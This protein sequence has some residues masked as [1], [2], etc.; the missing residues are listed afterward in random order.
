VQL[1]EKQHRPHG[2]LCHPTPIAFV[3]QPQASRVAEKVACSN[4]KPVS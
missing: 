2:A 1:G 3:T 4:S